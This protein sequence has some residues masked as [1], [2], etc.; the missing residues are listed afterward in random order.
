[1]IALSMHS[2]MGA[3]SV[4]SASKKEEWMLQSSSIMEDDCSIHPPYGGWFKI[5]RMIPNRVKLSSPNVEK[6]IFL[7]NCAYNI[8]HFADFFALYSRVFYT[9]KVEKINFPPIAPIIW[10]TFLHFLTDKREYGYN[11]RTFWCVN[12]VSSP[13]TRKIHRTSTVPRVRWRY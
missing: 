13:K 2:Q 10:G 7:S 5:W 1:M 6:T 3:K 12:K 11:H 8:E 4:Q 9:K